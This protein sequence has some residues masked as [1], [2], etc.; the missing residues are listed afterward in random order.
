MTAIP[1]APPKSR[2]AIPFHLT[3]SLDT[4]CVERQQKDTK[5]KEQMNVAPRVNDD[6]AADQSAPGNTLLT[7]FW[8]QRTARVLFTALIF[9]CV[10]AFLHRAAETL[11]LFLFAVLFAYFVE[12]LVG[13][14]ERHTRGRSRAIAI[15]YIWLLGSLVVL[16][17]G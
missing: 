15:V 11:T 16:G 10:L 8:D 12:P 9:A 7:R 4:S 5:M 1:L 3:K 6:K 13:K 14:I 2:N 17:M